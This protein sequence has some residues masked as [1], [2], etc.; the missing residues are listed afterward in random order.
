[1]AIDYPT[2]LDSFTDKQDNID[3]VQA[4]DINDVQDACMALE[5]KVGIDNSTV[6]TSHDYKI[7]TLEGHLESIVFAVDYDSF[8]DAVSDIGSNNVT[9]ITSTSLTLTDNVTVPSNISII[10]LEGTLFS[11]AYDLTINGSFSAGLYQVF[12]RDVNVT[13]NPRIKYAYP[14]WFGAEGDGVTDDIAAI[15]CLIDS[16]DSF[17]TGE[18]RTTPV[19]L[20]N[21]IYYISNSINFKRYTRLISNGAKLLYGGTGVAVN[22]VGN[23]T[24]YVY[25]VIKGVTIEKDSLDNIGTGIL[26]DHSRFGGYFEDVVIQGFEYGIIHQDSWLNI[27]VDVKVK[28]NTY[29]ALFKQSSN[30]VSIR[31]CFFNSN[32]DYGLKAETSTNL[33]VVNCEFEGNGGSAVIFDG[34]RS[35][36][37]AG[38]YF[39][40]NGSP[41]IKVY[42]STGTDYSY[43]IQILNNYMQ[44]LGTAANGI[45]IERTQDTC[46]LGNKIINFTSYAID[47]SST[48]ASR[49]KALFNALTDNGGTINVNLNALG[50]S[51]IFDDYN[52]I[53]YKA[54]LTM[55]A[56]TPAFI[57]KDEEHDTAISITQSNTK[58]YIRNIDNNPLATIDHTSRQFSE[59]A[60]QTGS[61]RPSSPRLGQLFLDTSINKLIWFDGTNWRDTQGTIV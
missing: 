19:F 24:S 42:E 54:F 38:N 32:S 21:N 29:G 56:K 9:L 5:E 53:M 2:A 17:S 31:D 61:T 47:L 25:P 1:M 26:I 60:L 33:R 14:E 12:D 55:A 18:A 30:G 6:T 57:L 40:G 27:F 8:A 34:S 23:D 52:E 11:G 44:G 48:T 46:I 13:G 49:M 51:L 35:S 22:C 45:V 59:F 15:Q 4:V 50:E 16:I 43:M 28:S 20:S 41:H 37:I 3:V 39:E 36:I 58:T 7:S 10:A